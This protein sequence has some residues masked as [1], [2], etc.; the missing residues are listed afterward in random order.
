MGGRSPSN[1]AQSAPGS[2][3]VDSARPFLANRPTEERRLIAHIKRILERHLADPHFRLLLGNRQVRRGAL[4]AYGIVIDPDEVLPLLQDDDAARQTTGQEDLPLVRLW[5]AY[6]SDLEGLRDAFLNAG[7]CP[8]ANPR[9][10][11]WRHRQIRRIKSELGGAAF[12]M[13]HPIL[14]F[15]LSVGCSVGCWFC[16]VSAGRLRGSFRRTRRNAQLWRGVLTEATRLFGPAARTGFCYWATDP[17][18]NPDYPEFIQDFRRITGALPGTTTAAP[19]KDLAFTRRLLQLHH[20][21]GWVPNRFSILNLKTLDRVHATFTAEEL[22]GV[23]L[24][25]QNPEAAIPKALAGRMRDRAAKSPDRAGVSDGVEDATIACVNGFLTNMVERTVRLVS[26]TRPGEHWPLGYRVYGE[27]S[28]TTES[29]FRRAVEDL[30]ELHMPVTVAGA[31]QLGFREDLK[32]RPGLDG[33]TLES[34]GSRFELTGFDGAGLLG[35]MLCRGDQRAG[36]IEATLASA[37]LDVIVVAD[38]LEKMF[39]RSLFEREP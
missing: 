36:E 28:F 1:A 35:D 19:L 29:D 13:V 20:A 10:D 22:F 32:Y 25:L 8:E 24:V 34:R 39:E 26:P 18:D 11:A 7:E 12:G 31:G 27:R 3:R 17:S 4:A 16:G 14:A 21:H 5:Q 30:I 33:F 23:E 6:R 38:L 2:V 15:E 9:F 37:G